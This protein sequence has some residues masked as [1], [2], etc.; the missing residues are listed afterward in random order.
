MPE[1]LLLGPRAA[2]GSRRHSG[3]SAA[4]IALPKPAVPSRSN[5]RGQMADIRRRQERASSG[6]GLKADIAVRP[7]NR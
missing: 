1:C 5:V 3:R 6:I 7:S 4:Q 2:D